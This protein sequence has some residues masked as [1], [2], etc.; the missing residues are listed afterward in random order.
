V[1]FYP[2]GDDLFRMSIREWVVPQDREF[3]V[4]FEEMADTVRLS[5]DFLV[6][7][8]EDYS[9]LK[10]KCHRMKQFEH[11]GDVITHNIYEHLNRT[12]I[13]PLEPE[14]ISALASALD[15]VLDYIEGTTA[16]M[17]SYGIPN[18]D[19]PMREFSKI[20]QLSAIELQ[21]AVRG[22]STLKDP[23]RIEEH[24]IEINRLENLADEVLAHAI[25]DLFQTE[26]A[27]RIIKLKDV[28]ENLEAATDKCEDAA[29]VLSDIVIRHT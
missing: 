23:K 21:G 10:N 3:F 5:A 20:I 4:L 12:F 9:D 2:Y 15:D 19:A 7:L 26:D 14:E 6:L 28:Y 8:M 24:C 25:R 17:H 16:Q 29:N 18:T 13:T 1:D 22:I 11:Q 27:I